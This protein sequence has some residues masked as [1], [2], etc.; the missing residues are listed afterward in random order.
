MRR[1]IE[2]VPNFSEGRDRE[3]IA[4]LGAVMNSVKGAW[5]LDVH[6]DPDHNR[7]VVTL[8]GEPEPV[9]EAALRGVGKAIDWIDLRCHR[10]E[11]PRIGAIDVL[12]FVPMEGVSMEDCV[13]LARHTG[14]E[15]WARYE[16]PVYFYEEA[17]L[18]PQRKRLESVR[19][20]EFEYLRDEVLRNADRTPDIGGPR[21]HPSA[22]AVAVGA[23]KFLI[24]YNINLD[25]PDVSIARQ[26]ARA[27]RASSGGLPHVKAIGVELKQRKLAQ[28][29]MNLTDF[30]QTSLRRVFEA[31]RLE[32][33]RHG[34]SIRGSEIVG[35]APRKALGPDDAAYLQLENFS[36]AEKILE[37]RLEV[38]INE[39]AS[40]GISLRSRTGS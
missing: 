6:S 8:A 25:T 12:P 1:L 14:A 2:C 9:A 22:G 32:A 18:R 35:L 11:H 28:V 19:S 26:I 7:S 33:Q 30:E 13:A 4:A 3:R 16:V 36:A 10:G 27:I 23:R 37:T 40:D 15:I 38:K 24:A 39:E 5:V 34:C 20:G 17:A 31:V 21:L 29:S